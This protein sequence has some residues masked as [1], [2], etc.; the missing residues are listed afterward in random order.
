MIRRLEEDLNRILPGLAEA[1]PA[2][3][4]AP[5]PPPPQEAAPPPPPTEPMR[6]EDAPD[7]VKM[8]GEGSP[9][10]PSFTT[11]DPPRAPDTIEPTPLPTPQA[12]GALMEFFKKIISKQDH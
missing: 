12:H 9:P 5:P 8:E 1:E 10:A 3:Q 4:S 6:A 11:D 2:A 7:E